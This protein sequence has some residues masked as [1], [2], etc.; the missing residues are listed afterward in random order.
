MQTCIK[1]RLVFICENKNLKLKD[2]Q[3]LTELPYRTA[4]SYLNGTRTPNAEGLEVICTR[5]R[6]NLNWLVC[7]IGEP[8][9]QEKQPE[10]IKLDVDEK[11]LLENYRQAS[12]NGKFVISSVARSTEKKANQD[13]QIQRYYGT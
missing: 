9:I 3:E 6:V 7:G 5:L 2:F 4:Q 11:E 10:K 8:F 13:N 1:E 12:D